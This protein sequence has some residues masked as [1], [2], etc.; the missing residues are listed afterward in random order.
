M[1]CRWGIPVASFKVVSSVTCRTLDDFRVD[2]RAC[3]APIAN[4]AQ[5]Y[6]SMGFNLFRLG[7]ATV[8][9]SYIS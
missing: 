8:P 4:A 6:G 9:I 7:S 3:P 2:T 5:A 1:I